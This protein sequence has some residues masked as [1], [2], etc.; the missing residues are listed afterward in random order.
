[1]PI[2]C[3]HCSIFRKPVKMTRELENDFAGCISLDE[4]RIC[5]GMFHKTKRPSP[6]YAKSA[7]LNQSTQECII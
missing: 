1:M 3:H 2:Q 5:K 7:K 6:E 4:S